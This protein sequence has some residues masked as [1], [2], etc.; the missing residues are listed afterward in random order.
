MID[1]A[2]AKQLL[3]FGARM[4]SGPR[5]DEQLQGAVAIHNIL[6]KH[7]VAYL[8]D[9]VGMGKTYV[10]L[11]AVAL[12]R[13]FHPDFRTLVIAPR[14]NIQRKWM[15][16]LGNFA[17]YNVKFTDFRNRTVD[18]QPGRPLV[19]CNSLVHLVHEAVVD[20]RRDFFARLSSFS[21]GLSDKE[22]DGGEGYKKLRNRLV[23]AVP[24]LD[25]A[26]ELLSIRNKAEFKD[27]VA[28][29]VC[30]ALPE[31]D[32]VIV[33]EGHNLKHGFDRNVAAR[34][35]VLALAF[36]HPSEAGRKKDFPSYGPRA[37]RVLFLSATPL[38]ETYRH[39]WNQL[40]VFGLG[41][42]F[43]EL[44]Q[45]DLDDDAKKAVA[46]K[47][48]VRRVTSMSIGGEQRTKNQ[49]RRDWRGGGVHLHD[50]SIAVVDPRQRLVVALV[51]KKVAELLASEKFNMSFQVG[52]LASFESFLET[53]KLKRTDEEG[54]SNFDGVG[55][56]DEAIEREGIDVS[57]INRLS[58][59]YRRKFGEELPHPKMDA[60]V[61]ALS[62]SWRHGR[63]S[64]VFVRRVASVKELKRKLDHCYDEWLIPHLRER[65]PAE[66]HARF[67]RVVAQYRA[68]KAL[69][70]E[71]RTARATAQ[72]RGETSEDDDG[73]AEHDD[74][75][76]T[77]SFFAWYFRGD[78]PKGVVSGANI[79]GRFIQSGAAYSTFFEQNYAADLL[80]VD[81]GGVEVALAAHL[82]VSAANCRA[83]L[84]ARA[85]NY[86]GKAK[87]H[88]RADRF[89][90]FQAAAVDLLRDAGGSV[91]EQAE[92]VWR[93]RFQSSLE[94]T[95]AAVAPDLGEE[96]ELRT[97]FTELRQPDRAEL[98]AALWP[99]PAGKKPVDIFRER[100]LRAQLLST[101]AR[102]GHGLIDLY[103][104]TIQR[105]KS[106]ELR[107]L[108]RGGDD[109]AANLGA[110][111]EYV[112]L[113][114][115]QR[116]EPVSQRGWAA[117][118]EL[119]EIASHF[120]LI[121]DV[122]APDARTTPLA[123][124]ARLFGTQLG[125]QQPVAGMSGQ[126]N[127][128][129]I[130]QFRMPGYPFVLVS[131]DLLQEGE[132]LHTFCSQVFHYG[133][134]W[135]P[136]AMEQRIG[137]VDRVRSQT[138]RRLNG[139]PN[140]P[141]GDELLQ[142][143]Y[144]YLSDTV[145]VLQVNRVL[146]RMNTFIRLMHEGLAV[147]KGDHRTVDVN[148]ELVNGHRRVEA[149]TTRLKTAFPIPEWALQAK[150]RQL[151]VSVD[152]AAEAVLRFNSLRECLDFGMP[153]RWEAS[154]GEGRL[155]GTAS[156]ATGREQPFALLL[157]SDGSQ[158]IVRCVSPVGRVGTKENFQEVVDSAAG[159]PSWIGAILTQD[160]A[161]YDLTVEGDVCLAG[162]G[163]DRQRVGLL[164][165]RVLREADSVEQWH[166]GERDHRMPEFEVDLR[167][168][169]RQDH[170]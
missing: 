139:S 105:L 128:V 112:A 72:E 145:E 42:G 27:N 140:V 89:E 124:T 40:D 9:E 76:G 63:K 44:K 148:K 22:K 102:L 135:T 66:T 120:D 21:I 13:H 130:R 164:L 169:G 17:K 138:D 60:L 136:S 59:D 154:S 15:K 73:L 86:L 157:R 104:V 144:P 67:D 123:E 165:A 149:I 18:E 84:T 29:A 170:E 41:D 125:R 37:K 155:L 12:F 147:P 153:V 161:Q 88:Q 69:V 1:V 14:E 77:D 65:L 119:A 166:F 158:L 160:A 56:A 106:L 107:T 109:E 75:G 7:R 98:R 33:D 127:Q 34:N 45:A 58:R 62:D 134:S 51:Q 126:I 2:T 81:P 99:E 103:I 122:N 25:R 38:E 26:A 121:L 96:L 43:A 116:T 46:A 141:V 113:L 6:Q 8:A 87:R 92:L 162:P 85:R 142:V 4:G 28:R 3:D 53:T 95:P 57:D 133:I 90:A 156:F 150:P 82:R 100:Q 30:C 36:G 137:R 64:L 129:V 114:D 49:Y 32:L 152:M 47:F 16:E 31:F 5:A 159:Q 115:S 80:G 132:D 20:P 118:D 71:S 78:G 110:I 79:Q 68:E 167:R 93:E 108:G 61:Q 35:R 23:D 117:F 39:I 10:A 19:A 163:F 151:A 11:G 48:L 54:A 97:F 70:E 101:A 168:E 55:Q 94:R 74:R 111:K 52:M 24:W 83:A 131:T 50:D 91:G 143:F 146:A